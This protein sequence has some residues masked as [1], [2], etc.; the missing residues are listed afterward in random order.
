MRKLFT[1][2]GLAA[3]VLLVAG[4]SIA[5]AAST[6]TTSTEGELGTLDQPRPSWL[7]DELEAKIVAAGPQGIEVPLSPQQALEVNCLGTAPPYAGTS[8][9]SLTAVAAGTCMVSPAGCTMNF[10]FTNGTSNY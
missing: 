7:T 4:A 2:L 9:V 6:D 3:A 10:I 8:G 5:L 1:V